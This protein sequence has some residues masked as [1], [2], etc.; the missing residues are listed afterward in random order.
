MIPPGRWFAR[1]PLLALKLLTAYVHRSTLPQSASLTAPSEREPG[2][3]GL[4][5]STRYSL[6]S[7]VAG[8]FRRPYEGRVP[9]IGVLAE[10]RGYGRFSSPLR[11]S[12][13][14]TFH[15]AMCRPETG[16]L[17][18]DFHRPYE[19]VRYIGEKIR[20]GMGNGWFLTQFGVFSHAYT[21]SVQQDL[22]I[23]LKN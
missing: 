18:G 15:H 17:A 16:G 6:N 11:N 12:E 2:T 5:H 20:W 13:C 10:I 14:F 19:R 8:D 7:G 4:H 21:F 23:M 22:C 1:K 3:A 9:F